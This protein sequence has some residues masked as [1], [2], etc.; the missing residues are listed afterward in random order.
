MH[1]STHTH[2]GRGRRDRA[3][4]SYVSFQ[5]CKFCSWKHTHN[6]CY[7]KALRNA[8]GSF[9]SSCFF[10][11]SFFS[12]FHQCWTKACYNT[13]ALIQRR[14]NAK[15]KKKVGRGGQSGYVCVWVWVCT[16]HCLFFNPEK[17]QRC[18][19]H[20][21]N[22]QKKKKVIHKVQRGKKKRKNNKWNGTVQEFS[23]SK[24]RLVALFGKW[25]SER[26]KSEH[27]E[28]NESRKHDFFKN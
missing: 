3:T 19:P 16:S 22:E 1:N 23:A 26:K 2:R 27:A 18:T 14:T 17:K 5:A 11:L 8:H 25:W 4:H 6:T 10:P 15:K 13:W 12:L 21:N 20:Y 28:R 7:L 9:C 24:R